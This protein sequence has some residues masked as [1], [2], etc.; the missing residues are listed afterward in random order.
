MR[1]KTKRVK[2]NQ[3]ANP[4]LLA[5]EAKLAL[6]KARI[7]TLPV[8]LTRNIHARHNSVLEQR[9]E[10]LLPGGN[11]GPLNPLNAS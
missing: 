10:G 9:E 2:K 7:G 4:R 8:K 3:M 6:Q 5:E 1:I 11:R